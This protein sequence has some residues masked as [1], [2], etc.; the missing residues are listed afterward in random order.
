MLKAQKQINRKKKKPM[1]L[2]QKTLIE[3]KDWKEK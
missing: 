1:L 2:L 3:D